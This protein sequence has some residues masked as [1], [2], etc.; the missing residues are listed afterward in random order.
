MDKSNTKP[1]PQAVCRLVG[2]TKQ[3]ERQIEKRAL[4]VQND[5]HTLFL[6]ASPSLGSLLG[7]HSPLDLLQS[8]RPRL[9]PPFP[10]W[11]P[12]WLVLNLLSSPS[13]LSPGPI[14]P[15]LWPQLPS[16]CHRPPNSQL[17]PS[18]S[19]STQKDTSNM[20]WVSAWSSGLNLFKTICTLLWVELYLPKIHLLKF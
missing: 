15:L 17:Q 19:L 10:C 5:S 9:H 12:G 3:N 6:E 20:A 18:P 2:D 8:H 13:T 7:L 16:P 1:L 11:V 14:P 4:A